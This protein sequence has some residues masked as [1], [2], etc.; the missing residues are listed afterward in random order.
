MTDCFA[1]LSEPRRLWL[2]V[3]ALKA[4]RDRFQLPLSDDDVEHL[5]FYRP[6]KDGRELTY[7]RQRRAA[8]GG[9]LPARRRE[10]PPVQ[11]PPLSSYAQFALAA[12]NKAMS[13]TMAAVRIISGLLRDKQL[14]PR[15]V[16]IV[17]NEARTLDLASRSI[18]CFPSP[19]TR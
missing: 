10:A 5:R 16:P 6:D 9:A 2:D 1:L 18:I 8:L 14:G 11:V 4:F 17:A 7:L 3:D 19:R 12:E 15:I 13:T